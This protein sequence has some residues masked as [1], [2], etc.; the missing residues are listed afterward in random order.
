MV[1][2]STYVL[3]LE[4]LEELQLA[5]CPLGEDRCAEWLHNLLHGN[6]LAG[7]LIFG[8]AIVVSP[9][10][11]AFS[12]PAFSVSYTHQTSPKAPIPTG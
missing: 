2:M 11:R 9:S 10:V 1:V 8:R 5:V 7:K 6:G 12:F 4:M 3:V